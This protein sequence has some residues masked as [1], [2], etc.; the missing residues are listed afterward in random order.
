MIPP[1]Q[2]G[3]P[4]LG[5]LGDLKRDPLG[6][7]A[8]AAR[9]HGDVVR[10]A[11]P[12]GAPVFLVNHPDLIR[13]VLQD[14]AANYVR[15]PFHHRLKGLLG[16]GLVTSE[17]PLWRRQRR[18]MQPAF[19][20]GRVRSFV[21]VMAEAVEELAERWGAGGDVEMSEEMSALTLV[22]I[23]RA[24]FSRTR[25]VGQIGGG[26]VGAVGAAVNAIQEHLTRR[27]WAMTEWSE[28]LP[29][30]ANRRY[31]AAVATADAAVSEIMAARAGKE[32]P[33]D[34][35]GMLLAARDED[36]GAGMSPK[37]VRDEVMTMF[38]AG[39]ETSATGLAWTWALLAQ[40]ADIAER[41][42]AEADAVLD[43]GRRP[44]WVDV[45][46][47][48]YTRMVVQEAMRLYPPVAWF[49]RAVAGDDRLGRFAVPARALVV[50]S[51][52]LMQRDPR[53]WPNPERFDPERFGSEQ[54]KA[55]PGYAYF[56]FGGG[57][58]T[59]IGNHFALTEMVVAV[60]MLAQRF[61]MELARPTPI[62]GRALITL[63]VEG[64]LPMRVR[65]I[66]G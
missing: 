66:G 21:A 10:L 59:C 41:V 56:P 5:V 45:E 48:V 9:A 63:R 62:R 4:L 8:E 38:M 64:G 2:R 35:L 43:G 57:P 65:R 11:L 53:F 18:L 24:M 47:L 40:H 14:N 51:P 20:A 6:T 46:R 27:F 16:E 19:Q 50:F 44:E 17:G 3:V 23:Q 61:A 28:K 7:F 32:G 31:R 54:A 52:Y 25:H 26:D 58:R 36:S 34:L 22:I 60:A 13:R 15:S 29:T 33:D 42:R 49:G 55:R 39:H 12:L 30:P 1:V 37:Q